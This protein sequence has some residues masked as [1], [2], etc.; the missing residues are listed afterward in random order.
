MA[1]H[2]RQALVLVNLGNAT[3]KEIL[4]LAEEIERRIKEKLGLE[5]EREVEIIK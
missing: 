5:I 3:A 1:V 2:G 4:L